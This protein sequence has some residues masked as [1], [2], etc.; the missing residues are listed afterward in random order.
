MLPQIRAMLLSQIA[1]NS[2][3]ISIFPILLQKLGLRS[4]CPVWLV[5][6]WHVFSQ[7]VSHSSAAVAFGID[8]LV[9]RPALPKSH[10]THRNLH[11]PKRG[12]RSRSGWK[13][14]KK[15]EEAIYWSAQK[16][17]IWEFAAA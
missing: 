9:Q 14:L 11:V 13:E 15:L 5:R 8:R 16:L 3:R 17:N 7:G 12:R 6:S 10:L 1:K 2:G 4:N